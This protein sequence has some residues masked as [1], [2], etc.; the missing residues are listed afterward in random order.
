MG[1]GSISS[2]SKVNLTIFGHPKHNNSIII[3]FNFCMREK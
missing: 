1:N 2:V 3:F